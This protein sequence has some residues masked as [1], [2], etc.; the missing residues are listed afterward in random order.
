MMNPRRAILSHTARRRTASDPRSG[1][2]GQALVEFALVL[3]PLLLILTG[4]FSM[5]IVINQY[6]VLTNAVG[7]GARAFALSRDQQN[8]PL[9]ASDKCAFAFQT[10]QDAAPTLDPSNLSFTVIYTSYTDSS[11]NPVSGGTVSTLS[12]SCPDLTLHSNDSVQISATYTTTPLVFGWSGK[13]L[14]L[15]A[16]AAEQVQ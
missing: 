9:A 7:D 3:P 15:K 14:H 1:N 2:R 13:A 5:G 8:P 12:A 16:T 4:L 6:E 11:G 10:V